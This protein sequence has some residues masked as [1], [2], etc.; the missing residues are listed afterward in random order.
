MVIVLEEIT[1]AELLS[2]CRAGELW[3]LLDVRD[4]KEL[5]NVRVRETAD[6]LVKTIPMNEI[7]DRYGE[8]DPSVSLAVLCHSGGRSARVAGFLAGTGLSRVVNVR[9]G[10]EAWPV[11]ATDRAVDE[12]LVRGPAA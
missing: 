2:R 11:E 12:D 7:P 9:G 8:L 3:H 10:I 5:E 6:L 1:P 4:T